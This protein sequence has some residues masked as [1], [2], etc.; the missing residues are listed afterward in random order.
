MDPRY[1]L[2]SVLLNDLEDGESFDATRATKAQCEIRNLSMPLRFTN[3]VHDAGPA[4][5]SGH[6]VLIECL[7]TWRT[8]TS[9]N[10]FEGSWYAAFVPLFRTTHETRRT[11]WPAHTRYPR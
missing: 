1:I 3:V 8:L 6:D 9:L 10:L 2:S 7:T 5:G 11:S 4:R